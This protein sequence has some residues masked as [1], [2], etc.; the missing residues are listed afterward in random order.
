MMDTSPPTESGLGRALVGL[1]TALL[2][3]LSTLSAHAATTFTGDKI[4]GLPVITQLDVDDLD[5]GKTQRFMFRGV[6]MGTGEFW[7]VP[8]IVAKG[9]KPGKRI[10][11]VAGVHG[12]ELNPMRALQQVFADIDASTLSGSVVG[13]LGASRPGVEWVTRTW[14]MSNLGTVLINPNRTWPGEESGNTVERHCWLITNQ[15][16]KGNVDVGVDFHTGGT[17]IDFALFVFAYATDPEARRMAELF[18]VDQIMADPGLPGTL[19][20]A[21]VQAGIP[22]LTVELGGPRGFDTE[23]IRIGVEGAE[24]LLAHY[25]MTDRPVG[26]TAKDR[27]VFRG[28]KL[29]DIPSVTGGFVELLVKLNDEVKRGQKVAIQRNSFGDVVHEYTAGVDGR[30][31]IIGTDAIRERGVTIVT[32]LTSSSDCPAGG[33]PYHGDDE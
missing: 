10:L 31:A 27:N 19:E 4:Q 16:I 3:M 32:I 20:Y 13:I 5:P 15:L 6:E 18:P 26:Q 9:G 7:Y 11:L 12:D 23:M 8:V 33:C 1:A 30:V 17:G 25:K 22:A 2:T 28:N 14:P 24:N 21:L 29:E